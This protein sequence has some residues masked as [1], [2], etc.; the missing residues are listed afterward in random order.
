MNLPKST[1]LAINVIIALA[2]IV[3]VFVGMTMDTG[4][5]RA[6]LE[7]IG[8]GLIAAGAVNFF[9]RFLTAEPFHEGGELVSLV[10][11]NAD[12][13]IYAQKHNAD[14]V[15]VVGISLREC[16][17]D[18]VDDTGQKMIN[19]ILN[20]HS[21]FRLLLVHPDAAYINQRAF[22]DK[23]S[24]ESLRDRQR[25]S[26]E[27]GILF[28][29]RLKHQYEENSRKGTLHTKLVGDFEIKL[30]D[31]CPYFSIFR[32]D[33]KIYWG[34]YASDTTGTNSPL[35][36]TEQ[37]K[38]P[39]LFEHFKQHFYALYE[40]DLNGQDNFLLRMD[41]DSP[42]LNLELAESVLGKEKVRMLLE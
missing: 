5:F 7:S 40:K 4:V 19:R 31:R 30:I 41:V 38:N 16:M 32:V 18:I 14:K 11:A 36:L 15:D 29:K 12:D 42:Y 35:F 13:S 22:E 23:I 21:R 20:H 10:R 25:R 33:K 37:D 2:G 8:T 28:Y 6:L 34:L 24:V 27:L 1:I 39:A 9:D 26:I 17:K 3:L